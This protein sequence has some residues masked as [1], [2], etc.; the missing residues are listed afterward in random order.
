[1]AKSG[2]FSTNGYNGRHLVFSWS[3]LSQSESEN[4]TTITYALKGA[5]GDSQWY[6]LANVTLKIDGTTVYS[7]G[8]EDFQLY[9]GTTVTSGIYTV[10]HDSNGNASFSASVEAGIYYHAPNC[11]GS[12]SWE[13]D[14]FDPASQPTCITWPDNTEEVGDFG[15][16]ISIHMNRK[17]SAYTH[18]VYYEFGSKKVTIATGVTTGCTWT[19]PLDLMNEIPNATSGRGRIYA[20][21]YK[22]NQF[23][24]TKYCGFVAT[25]P[26]SV[27][28][29]LSATLDDVTSIDTIYGSP[30]RG[31]SKIKVTATNV[32][33]KYSATIKSYAIVIDGVRYTSSSVTTGAL[34]N[35]GDSPVTVTV[36]DSRGRSGSW[37]YTMK[38]QDYNT[39]YVTKMTAIRC[40]QSGASDDRGAYIKVTFSAKIY[41][42]GNQNTALYKLKYRKT[43]EADYTIISLV[44]I[45]GNYAPTDYSYIISANTG[46]AY[47]IR[48]EAIDRHTQASPGFRSTKAPAATAIM[49]WRGFKSDSGVK[50]GIGIGRVPEKE[51]TFQVGWKSEFEKDVITTG[52]SYVISS[53]G[54][55]GEAGYVRMAQ[56]THK[57]ANADTPITFVFTRRLAAHPMTVHVQFESNS[58]TTD[59]GLETISYEGDN[60]GA[61]LVKSSA[62]VWDLYVEKA[63]AYDMVTMQAWYSS[64]TVTD[65]LSLDFP[66]DL[67]A[68]LPQGLVGYYRA[69][70][71]KAQNLLDFIYPVGSIYLAYNHTSPATLFGG[72]WERIPGTLL[73][74]ANAGDNIGVKGYTTASVGGKEGTN[75]AYTQISA[76]RR[77]A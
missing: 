32:S 28:P 56:L 27:K 14:P 11:T 48:V 1:M 12:G 51:D 60:Y 69:T 65:R 68:T 75:I 59:P 29:T 76:W 22:G 10:Q 57:K 70:P 41:N 25:V 26:A 8:D 2:S 6:N 63:S 30:V 52:N 71:A 62:S 16:T 72:T 18:S 49:S 15:G 13:I 3:V 42:L 53:P 61:F 7:H 31:L 23:I 19:I 47:E 20:N 5:G 73:Y 66:G 37:S 67:V 46:N 54:V 36:T 33:A 34:K 77:T 58:Q 55:A 40:N 4:K 39:P 35:A 45:T 17:N 44:D 50:T 38:V 24:G 43:S 64:G 74:A 21:T 9:N